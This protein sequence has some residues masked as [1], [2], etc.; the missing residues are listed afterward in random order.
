MKPQEILHHLTFAES[1]PK[2]ALRAATAQ[3]N[4]ML[5]LFL[6]QIERYLAADEAERMERSPLLLIFHLFGQWRETAAYR[7]LLQLLRCPSEDLDVEFGDCI[8][9]T[10]H[11]VIAAVFDGD[12]QPLYD[13]ILDIDADEFVRSRLCEVVAML[14]LRGDIPRPEAVRFLRPLFVT[15]PQDQYVRNSLFAALKRCGGSEAV[16]EVIDEAL[17]QH[18]EK[19]FLHGLRR[20]HGS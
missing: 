6:E 19:G 14:A 13:A 9:E 16:V 17:A 1:F 15:K 20:K 18:P 3:R 7:P 10:F 11:R 12:L 4:E 5:P 2:H 8:T